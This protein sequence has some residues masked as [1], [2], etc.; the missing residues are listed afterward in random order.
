MEKLRS[1]FSERLNFI[2]MKVFCKEFSFEK[3]EFL[4]IFVK[5]FVARD[6]LTNINNDLT[7]NLIATD[8]DFE[9]KCYFQVISWLKHTL[10]FT[11]NDV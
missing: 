6:D 7:I 4:L 9:N 5:Q 10:T 8:F 3:V 11:L 1:L 2:G